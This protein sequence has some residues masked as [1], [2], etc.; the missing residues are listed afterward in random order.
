MTD[1]VLG[2][3]FARLW[4]LL[5]TPAELAADPQYLARVAEVMA[6]PDDYPIPPREGPSR[7]GLLRQLDSEAVGA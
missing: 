2:R 3:G 7:E 4:N 5:A 1:P 6:H